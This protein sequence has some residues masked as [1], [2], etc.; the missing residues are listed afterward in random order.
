MRNKKHTLFTE[1]YRPESLDN[2]IGNQVFKDQVAGW[3]DK[4]DC[5]N[6]LLYGPPGTGKTTAAKLIYKNLN[7]VHLYLNASDDNGIYTVRGEIKNFASA[8][9]LKPLKVV[10]L[11]DAFNMTM[12]AQQGILNIIETYSRSTRFILTTNHLEKIIPA[13]QSRC[14]GATYLI[15]PPNKK[16]IAIHLAGICD[17]EEVKYDPTD[18]V[19]I[20]NKHYPDIRSC[21]SV[22]QECIDD[23]KVLQNIFGSSIKSSYLCDVLEVL[24]K[25]GKDAWMK[26]RKLMMDA[27]VTNYAEL[28][29]YLYNHA[30]EFAGKGYEDTVLTIAEAQKWDSSVPDREIN[31]AAMFLQILKVI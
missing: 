13:L 27:G 6:I 12:D 8:S 4:N 31:T 20:I 14:K 5:P 30:E 3:I 22:L 15:E 18:I 1:I 29:T 16:E 26:I 17:Q 7:C 28:F 9:T 10:V 23:N 25:P 11:D 24:K 19:D 2:Y 21:V